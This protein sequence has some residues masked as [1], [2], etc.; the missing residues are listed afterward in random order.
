MFTYGPPQGP[1]GLSE[2]PVDPDQLDLPHLPEGHTV[3]WL[4]VAGVA[5]GGVI[6]AVGARFELHPLALGDVVNV[7]QR[8]KTEEYEGRLFIVTRMPAVV[9]PQGADDQ[10]RRQRRGRSLAPAPTRLATEQVSLCVGPNFLITFQEAPGDVFEPVRERLR[11]GGQRLRNSGPD[12]LAYALLD[13]VVDSY[14]PVLE[15]FGERLEDL[16]EEVVERPQQAHIAEIHD[17]KRDLLTV[18][19][20][21]WPQRDMLAALIRDETPLVTDETRIF[22]RDAYDH[23]VQLIDVIET[24]REIASGLVD[25]QLSSASNRMNEVM[26]V[27]TIIATIFIPLTF[28]AGVYGMN[29]DPE[30]SPWSMPELD[31]A[32]GYP[33]TLGVMAVIAAGLLW[34]FRRRGWL[35]GGG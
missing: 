29:F 27:L 25:I 32:Y 22:L 9:P 1:S 23:T 5:N 33:A 8:P 3:R 6:R 16:E 10:P 15:A 31:W 28:I 20:A 26:K 17:L 12:Y 30:A 24:Y 11:G 21:V 2:G 4:D 13:A 34:Y 35:G 7:S 14:F 19:R 18:R